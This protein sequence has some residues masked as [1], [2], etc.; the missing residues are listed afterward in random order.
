MSHAFKSHTV[1]IS[2]KTSKHM[3]FIQNISKLAY[4]DLYNILQLSS[5]LHPSHLYDLLQIYNP[6]ARHTAPPACHTILWSEAYKEASD[7]KFTKAK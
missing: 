3:Y 4:C 6:A 1:D 7:C 2:Y 5:S